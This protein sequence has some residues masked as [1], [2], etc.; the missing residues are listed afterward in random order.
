MAFPPYFCVFDVVS[1][2]CFFTLA[3][4]VSQENLDFP[5][6]IISKSFQRKVFF[7]F[8]IHTSELSECPFA[9]QGIPLMITPTSDTE[10]R[11]LEGLIHSSVAS[12]RHMTLISLKTGKGI[13]P[14][15][16]A[17]CPEWGSIRIL[18]KSS[19]DYSIYS[20]KKIKI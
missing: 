11:T 1:W 12:G 5:A 3:A 18:V 10:E 7:L 16:S 4:W 6:K 8:V 17:V 2:F 19:S 14:E 9:V 13:K 15:Y 20:F